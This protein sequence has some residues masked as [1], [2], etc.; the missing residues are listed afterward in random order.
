[1]ASQETPC[2]KAWSSMVHMGN[3]Q[4]RV[5]LQGMVPVEWGVKWGLEREISPDNEDTFGQAKV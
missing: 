1:M 5:K 4:C 3:H 2:A